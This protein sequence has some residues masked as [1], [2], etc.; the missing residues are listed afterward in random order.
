VFWRS[1]KK[2]N[3]ANL[4]NYISARLSIFLKAI[5]LI[6]AITMFWFG[7]YQSAVETLLILMITILPVVLGNRFAVKIPHG[8]ETL[9]VLFVFM[10]LFLGEVQS[11]YARFWWWDLVLHSGSA[12]IMGILGFLLVYVLN[13]KRD[14]DINLNRNFVALFAFMFAVGIGAIWEVFEFTIDQIFGSNMQKSGLVDTMWDLIV[15]IIGAFIISVLGWGYIK[16]READSFLERWIEEF[17]DKN[18]RFFEKN[19]AEE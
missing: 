18:P 11:Y 10:S 9:T 7:Q 16:T 1:R 5:L 6:G 3:A 12:F 14:L 2:I 4:A 15:D 17:I 8:F 19:E 13:E